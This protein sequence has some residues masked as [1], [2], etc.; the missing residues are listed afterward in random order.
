MSG[1][2]WPLLEVIVVDTCTADE[3]S[4]Q[5]QQIDAIL[6]DYWLKHGRESV[7]KI[8]WCQY[9]RS[10]KENLN[11]VVFNIEY[12]HFIWQSISNIF[13]NDIVSHQSRQV[14][15]NTAVLYYGTSNMIFS[16][17]Y[18]SAHVGPKAFLWRFICYLVVP[19]KCLGILGGNHLHDYY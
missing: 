5:W 3:K 4:P 11:T 12:Y 14:A 10:S 9:G 19:L 15:R 1:S 17:V 7:Y 2:E 8:L 16:T 13:P 18:C 6:I